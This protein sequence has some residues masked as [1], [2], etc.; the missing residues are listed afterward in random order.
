MNV[1]IYALATNYS[2]LITFQI[3]A[4]VVYTTSAVRN[5]LEKIGYKSYQDRKT[6]GILNMDIQT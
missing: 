3:V 6:L 2:T 1:I 5:V 4:T